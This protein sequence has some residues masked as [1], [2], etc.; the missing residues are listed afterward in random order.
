MIANMKK[1]P[2]KSGLRKIFL[3]VSIVAM[4]TSSLASAQ[5]SNPTA[6]ED[7]RADE[8]ICE[9]MGICGDLAATENARVKGTQEGKTSRAMMSIGT[10]KATMPSREATDE[11]VPSARQVVTEPVPSM[12]VGDNWQ[13]AAAT[14]AMTTIAP[15]QSETVS[16][17]RMQLMVNFALGSSELTEDSM[18]E[19]RSFVLSV[20]KL[21]DRGYR[22]KFRIEGHAD[23]SGAESINLPLSEQRAKAVHDLIVSTGLEEGRIEYAGYGSSVPLPGVR[24]DNYL[25][26]R[27]EAVLVE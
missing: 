6:A 23:S 7:A 14:G 12:P 20:K 10:V 24:S 18:L 21:D 22:K 17:A 25:N 9:M 2:M 13:T 15:S 26:R 16:D 4:A 3:N 5:V 27:V 8:M 1:L 19:I 11:P